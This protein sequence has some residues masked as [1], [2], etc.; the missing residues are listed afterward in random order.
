MTPLDHEADNG[1]IAVKA[2]AHHHSVGVGGN[3]GIGLSPRR[4]RQ[5]QPVIRKHKGT[6]SANPGVYSAAFNSS[7]SRFLLL[8]RSKG[9]GLASRAAQQD[10]KY[11]SQTTVTCLFHGTPIAGRRLP[12]S[13]IVNQ[14]QRLATT[15]VSTGTEPGGNGTRPPTQ[16][17]DGFSDA[18][19]AIWRDQN[20]SGT[21]RVF[22][23]GEPLGPAVGPAFFG[24]RSQ[25]GHVLRWKDGGGLQFSQCC[26]PGRSIA[27]AG[28]ARRVFRLSRGV[29]ER[30]SR[31]SVAAIR[32]NLA[33]TP[34]R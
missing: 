5:C 19:P 33:E 28:D 16:G 24:N 21:P 25:F 34:I 2:D 11:K 7:A 10:S 9:K 22:V 26:F 20:A 4:R 32:G 18:G 14:R 13:A 27:G 12:A 8:V 31:A 17:W 23:E 30:C 1:C 6:Q 29:P 15:M 3:P